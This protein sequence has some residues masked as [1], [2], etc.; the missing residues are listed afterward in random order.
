MLDEG[1]KVVVVVVLD[2][3]ATRRLGSRKRCR[4][5]DQ[6]EQEHE[7]AQPSGG[8]LAADPRQATPLFCTPERSDFSLE[9][10]YSS[11][12]EGCFINC[13]WFC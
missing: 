2:D 4:G 7:E 11:L 12:R 10:A 6:E 5:S 13:V 8:Q 9:S 3:G 1:Q